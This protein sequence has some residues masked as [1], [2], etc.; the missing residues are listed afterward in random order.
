M[1]GESKKR[2]VMTGGTGFIGSRLTE[3]LLRKGY[4]VDVITRSPDKHSPDPDEQGLRY[5]AMPN[6]DAEMAKLLDGAFGIVNLA[7]APVVG[8]RWSDE[9]KKVL[10]DSRVET[11]AMLVAGMEKCNDVPKKLISAS[12]VG[13][14]GASGEKTVTEDSPAGDDFLARL[15][16]AWEDEAKK[17]E[18]YGC[19]VALMRTGLVLDKN[20]GALPKLALPFRLY[21]G[22]KIGSGEQY[23]PWVHIDDVVD[24]YVW[25]LEINAG[26]AV[27]LAAP[28]PVKMKEFGK[29]LTRVFGGFMW[30]MVPGA[31]VKLAMGEASITVLAGQKAIPEK[32]LED[33]FGFKYAEL[34]EALN[35]IY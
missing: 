15:C 7:G 2:I 20:E 19:Q 3:E 25:Y 18:A 32:A 30:A 14:Y 9:R 13:Y 8:K 29:E 11:T 33:G 6:D 5:V 17:A 22:G 16:V 31:I 4:A 28:N 27:N 26:G 21:A 24:M 12:G 1:A 10:W 34:S 35:N 23:Y